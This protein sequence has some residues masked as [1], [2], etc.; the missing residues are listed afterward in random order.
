MTKLMVNGALNIGG[1]KVNTIKYL[2]SYHNDVS[3][4]FNVQVS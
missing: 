4:L 1:M 3:F 2:V